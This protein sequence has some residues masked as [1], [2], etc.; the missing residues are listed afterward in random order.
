[1]SSLLAW[2]HWRTQHEELHGHA[3]RMA[4]RIANVLAYRRRLHLRQSWMRWQGRVSDIT[5]SEGL[6]RKMDMS[7]KRRIYRRALARLHAHAQ[8]RYVYAF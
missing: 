4:S 3:S 7:F 1:M 6:Q 8:Y 2:R 5:F